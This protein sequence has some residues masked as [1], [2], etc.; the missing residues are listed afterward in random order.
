MI[1]SVFELSYF[2]RKR[3]IK[4]FFKKPSKVRYFLLG[5]CTDIILGLF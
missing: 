3:S 4:K 2:T 5:G 1:K